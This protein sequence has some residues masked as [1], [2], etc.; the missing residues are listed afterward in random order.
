MSNSSQYPTII[1]EDPLSLISIGST[2]FSGITT[3]IILILK[4]INKNQVTPEL[5]NL[6][7]QLP[8]NSPVQFPD[9]RPCFKKGTMILTLANNEETY[10]PIENLQKG[11]LVKTLLNGYKP[12]SLIGHGAIYNPPNGE[13]VSQRLYI[14]KKEMYPNLFE[15]LVITGLHSILIDNITDK[16][17][18]DITNL[19]GNVYVT[20]KKYRLMACIDD[21]S[22]PYDTEGDH[23]IYHIALE[24]EDC[25]QNYGIF[26]NGLLVE[27][28]CIAALTEQTQM[29]LM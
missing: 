15:D 17:R 23:D 27:T 8:P 19:V 14:C 10:I 9:D 12:I 29:E 11:N 1:I 22:E 4:G 18:R 25:Y 6:I 2:I 24:H 13:R 5:Q 3:P 26:A 21:R 7:S 20:D 16:Q 28:T